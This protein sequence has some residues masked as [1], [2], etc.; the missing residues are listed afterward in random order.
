MIIIKKRTV[1][2]FLLII[3][4]VIAI[5]FCV[6][7]YLKLNKIRVND[8]SS[9]IKQEEV[10]TLISK[11]SRLYLF[12]NN[13]TPTIATVSDPKLLKDQAFFTQA[14]IGD[15]VL[16]FV[17]AGRAVL[18]RPSVDKIIEITAIKNNSTGTTKQ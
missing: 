3:I 13:E 10:K 17:K 6:F 15:N 9:N 11:V 4:A 14:E 8:I 16:I 5:C 2:N 18:Y 1:F 7:F 12:P